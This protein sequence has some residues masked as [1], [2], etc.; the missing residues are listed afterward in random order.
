MKKL[1]LFLFLIL[2]TTRS[3]AQ[4]GGIHEYVWIQY[5]P[6]NAQVMVIATDTAQSKLVPVER[7]RRKGLTV[8]ATTRMVNAVFATVQ[9]FEAKGWELVKLEPAMNVAVL[10]RPKN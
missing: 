3:S 8:R 9:E 10:R 1:L 4:S 7:E 5:N 2:A 6:V